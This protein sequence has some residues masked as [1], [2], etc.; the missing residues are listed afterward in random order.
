MSAQARF[1]PPTT[2]TRIMALYLAKAKNDTLTTPSPLRDKTIER[3][4]AIYPLLNDTVK[5]L[6]AAT[7]QWAN[8]ARV[9]SEAKGKTV[10]LCSHF[11]QVFDM[12][13][14]RG[15]FDRTARIYFGLPESSAKLP[16]MIQDME[17]LTV[18]GNLI[19]GDAK[20]VE[21]GT[22]SSAQA[23]S[24]AAGARPLAQLAWQFAQAT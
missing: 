12:G 14:K 20:R 18:A 22:A 9:K 21:A 4:N 13:V 11:I 15:I 8:Q 3:L 1:F 24:S 17:I 7:A 6:N 2:Y 19:K 23:V 5:E 16:R 10:M